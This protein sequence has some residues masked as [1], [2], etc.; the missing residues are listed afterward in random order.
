MNFQAR[1]EGG[2]MYDVKVSYLRPDEIIGA[3][4][5]TNNPLYHALFTTS[6]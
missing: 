5:L 6:E 1:I 3:I 4:L 2:K